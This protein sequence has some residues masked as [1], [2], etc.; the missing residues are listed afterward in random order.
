[1]VDSVEICK[2]LNI[3]IEEAMKNPEMLTFISGQ[4]KKKMCKDAVKKLPYLIR[5]VHDYLAA[6]KLIPDMFVTCKII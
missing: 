1:M 4:K 6:L 2:S 5:Y 3:S